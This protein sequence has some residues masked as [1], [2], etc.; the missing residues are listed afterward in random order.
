MDDGRGRS[1]NE[2]EMDEGW[3]KNQVKDR[4]DERKKER[5]SKEV[6]KER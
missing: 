6:K 1:R 2:G 3:T 4:A 5:Q